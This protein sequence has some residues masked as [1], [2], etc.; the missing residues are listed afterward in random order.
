MLIV[1]GVVPGE[2]GLDALALGAVLCRALR[3]DPLLVH[4]H[5]AAYDYASAGHVDAEWNEYL[6]Q[7]S[8]ALLEQ[9]ARTAGQFGLVD[10]PTAMHAHRSSGVGLMEVAGNRGADLI[11][12]G[13][14]PG[15]RPGRFQIGSTADQLL[16]GSQLPVV[17]V[18]AGYAER[19][20]EALRRF[21]VAFQNSKESH[22]SVN[23]AGQFAITAGLPLTVLTV[24]LRHP[25]Y[26]S[27]LGESG[28]DEV[29][30]ALI[31]QTEDEQRRLLAQLPEAVHADAFVTVGDDAERALHSHAWVGDELLVL[32]SRSGSMRRVFL[33]DMTYKLLRAAP[34][35]AV[36]LPRRT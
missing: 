30:A 26:G 8:A 28:E 6:H 3:A 36:V 24:L 31:E 29:I 33:G 4:V 1:I 16:H 5:P 17:C 19:V 23:R 15:A 10:P 35:P 11:V 2:S 32:S 27:R 22:V 20:P 7:E 13:A 14:A 18:P 25:V 34:V 12:V 9:A 21:V